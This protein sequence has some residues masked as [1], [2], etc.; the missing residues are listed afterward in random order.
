MPTFNTKTQQFTNLGKY[1]G[2]VK[3]SDQITE[4]EWDAAMEAAIEAIAAAGYDMQDSD[5]L[6][7]EMGSDVQTL[8]TLAF[9]RCPDL[10]DQFNG[11][12]PFTQ[13]DDDSPDGMGLLN[14]A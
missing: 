1:Y 4:L 9:I 12:Q 2:E 6:G 13:D 14:N 3:A 11:A 10:M 8:L 7:E 5:Q